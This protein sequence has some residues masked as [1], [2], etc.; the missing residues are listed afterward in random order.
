M[1]TRQ[2][3]TI[4]LFA[5]GL[6]VV[7]FGAL[8]PVAAQQPVPTVT[9]LPATAAPT[10]ALPTPT[11]AP[12]TPTQVPPTATPPLAPTVAPMP[13]PT[14]TIPQALD[15]IFSGEQPVETFFTLL[16]QRPPL[17]I[18]GL[19]AL[20]LLIVAVVAIVQPW[21]E[22]FLRWID[23]RTGGQR[24]DLT[25]EVQREEEKQTL[26]EERAATRT[27]QQA[28]S[29]RDLYLSRLERD[30]LRL[31][32]MN[33]IHVHGHCPMRYAPDER[34][35]DHATTSTLSRRVHTGSGQTCHRTGHESRPRSA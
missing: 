32:K 7:F 31:T 27:Q 15:R 33:L 9:A 3:A 30:M 29:A 26:L 13:E 4:L 6:L 19:V 20:A 34:E 18:G 17:L 10:Q 16:A 23:R 8:T 28:T 1:P 5:I 25:E 11:V 14:F 21:R 35:G 12:A 2:Q 22:R 24:R